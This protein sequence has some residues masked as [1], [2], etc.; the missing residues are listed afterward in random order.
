MSVREQRGKV[1]KF[2]GATGGEN[3]Y[4]R[5]LSSAPPPASIFASATHDLL[6]DAISTLEKVVAKIRGSNEVSAI[7]AQWPGTTL[8]A[9]GCRLGALQEALEPRKSGRKPQPKRARSLPG[10]PKK[11]TLSTYAGLIQWHQRGV[12]LLKAKRARVT[13]VTAFREFILSEQDNGERL[14]DH[15]VRQWAAEFAKRLSDARRALLRKS[16]SKS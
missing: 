11:W 15:V 13:N 1:L 12:E 14:P 6:I 4:S 3:A 10:R 8:L 7:R 5:I 16:P 9:L 2:S